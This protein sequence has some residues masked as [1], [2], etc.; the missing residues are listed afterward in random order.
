MLW[1]EVLIVVTG[2]A[3]GDSDTVTV[4]AATRRPLE[5]SCLGCVLLTSSQ[6]ITCQRP[7]KGLWAMAVLTTLTAE[8]EIND[9]SISHPDPR[10]LT[11][12]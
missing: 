9:S 12:N 4:D 2:G 5:I 11:L 8:S 7:M 6:F 1:L 10:P 3:E